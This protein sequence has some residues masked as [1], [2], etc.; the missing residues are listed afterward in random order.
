VSEHPQF[1]HRSF[2]ETVDHPVAGPIGVPTYP[3]RI[4]GIDR[5]TAR[6]APTLGQHNAEVLGALGLDA[7]ELE[8]LEATG[9]TGTRPKGL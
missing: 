4:S 3:L 6:P 7:T 8:R 2:Y 9:V 1:V 5:W